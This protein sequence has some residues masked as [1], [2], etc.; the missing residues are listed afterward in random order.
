MH[1]NYTYN[2]VEISSMNSLNSFLQTKHLCVIERIPF[3][4]AK[5]SAYQLFP[6]IGAD[7]AMRFKKGPSL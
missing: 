7:E 1:S 3:H 6:E 5:N 4:S 2:F